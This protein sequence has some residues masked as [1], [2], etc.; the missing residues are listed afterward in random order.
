MEKES[1]ANS[2]LENTVSALLAART[3]HDTVLFV[4]LLFMILS[5]TPLLVWWGVSAGLVVI[6]VLVAPLLVLALIRWPILGL[7]VLALSA[8][9][10]ESDPLA[11]H[12]GTDNLYVFFWPLQLQGFIERPIGVLVLLTLF[13]WISHRW[14]NRQP[15]LKGGALIGPLTLYMLCVVFALVYGLGTG[16]DL[17]DAVI[18]IRPFWYT[19]LSYILA[20][21]FIT[22]KSHIRTFFWLAILSAGF[23]GLQGLYVYLILLHGNLA[24]HDVIMSHEESF[25]YAAMLLLLVIFCLHYR[26]RPQLIACLC[27]APP[28][29]MSL[30]ANQ[31]RADYI[32]LLLGIGLAWFIV[33][34]LKPKAR[35]ALVTGAIICTLLGVGYVLAFSGD[36]T[37]SF[38]SPARSIIGV[39]NPSAGDSRDAGSNL[40]RDYENYD[41]AYTARQHPLLG[42]GFGK[43]FDQPKPLTSIFPDIFTQDPVYDFVPH[44][45]IY[46]IWVDL[47]PIGFFSLWFLFGSIIVRGCFIA[48]QLKD[49]Y[50]QV[51]AIYIV[52]VTAMEVAVAFA[53]YQLYFFRNVI[54]LGLLAGILVKLPIL[55]QEQKENSAD[56]STDGA[57]VVSRPLVGSIHAKSPSAL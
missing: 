12:D 13:I 15:L 25:F 26:Y 8:F 1:L 48:R 2:K 56:K 40:Y 17:K 34:I 23:K 51:I 36:K 44:N 16:G 41:L 5:L 53:D 57:S 9:L 38:G 37:S 31:R 27:V 55:D 18:Q 10:I 52:A 11:I 35:R 50:L 45:T 3:R 24:G 14:I 19:F 6:G 47:G 21:N 29:L 42:L 54:D 30:V 43:K 33:F 49:P 20:Y 4:I 32:A 46:W 7:Y 22:R 28:V 39:F